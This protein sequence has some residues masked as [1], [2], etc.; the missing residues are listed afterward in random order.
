MRELLLAHSARFMQDRDALLRLVV[1]NYLVG[2]CDAHA[3]NYSI[4]LGAG[5]AVG[6]GAQVRGH[7]R[8]G[9]VHGRVVGGRGGVEHLDH[10]VRRP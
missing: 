5:G 6:V 10:G 1:F 7:A 2:N 3:K 9:R 4:M 8:E